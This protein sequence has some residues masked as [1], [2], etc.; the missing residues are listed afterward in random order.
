MRFLF[1]V[2]SLGRLNRMLGNKGMAD[3]TTTTLTE[4][5]PTMV[6]NA[7]L[8]LEERDV[9]RPLITLDTKLLGGPGVVSETPIVATLTSEADDS[10]S[11]QALDTGTVAQDTSP[12]SA[13]VGVHGSYV[14][15]KEI[16][17]LGSPDN[18]AAIA[19]QL[20]G[21]SIVT[22]R[23]LDLVTLFT[24]FSNNVGSANVDITP[25]DLYDAYGD[26]RTGFAPLPY[27]L[28]LHPLN[29]W[30]TVG[31]ISLFD[32]SS[33]AIQTQGPGTVGEDFAR[34]G[35]SGMVLG[36]RLWADAN[37][38][39]SSNN[40]S[41]LAFSREAIKYTIKRGL[42][43]DIESD[44]PEVATKIVGTE[45]WGES[46]LRDSHGTEMQFNQQP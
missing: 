8:A 3:T 23:D 13:T 24:S 38:V 45:I 15:L 7:L 40:A 19:G 10:L 44:A 16:A 11:S 14:Q 27:E 37:I 17:D 6:T 34:A 20:I 35:F 36:F 43:F 21:Q 29:I 30:S 31:L 5:I 42:R 4:A 9:V 2:L 25:G 1:L 32:N 46:E 33:D 41:G 18:M 28:V 39:V 22:R 12:S 26:L